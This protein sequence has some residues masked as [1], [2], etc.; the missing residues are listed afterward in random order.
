MMPDGRVRQTSHINQVL[1]IGGENCIERF[2]C[3]GNGLWYPAFATQK[4]LQAS[5]RGRDP[6]R[7]MAKEQLA[8]PQLLGCQSGETA[9]SPTTEIS[10]D[11]CASKDV[12]LASKKPVSALDHPVIEIIQN[13]TQ[14]WKGTVVGV[15]LRKEFGKHQCLLWLRGSDAA[16]NVECSLDKLFC[17]NDQ[18]STQHISVLSPFV[19]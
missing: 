18:G 17:D 4:T 3:R 13:T 1:L 10:F 14:Q 8:L 12:A 5:H 7:T 2:G 6:S 16:T 15:C 19:Q 9:W 11:C